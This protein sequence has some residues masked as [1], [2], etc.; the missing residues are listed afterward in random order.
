[1]ISG[2]ESLPLISEKEGCV[3]GMVVCVREQLLRSDIAE[4]R[5]KVI[6][7]K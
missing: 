1:L 3:S 4:N 7:R 5:G 2:G 6:L